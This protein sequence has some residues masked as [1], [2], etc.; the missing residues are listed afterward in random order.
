MNSNPD[1]KPIRFVD[2]N[3]NELFIVPDG[4]YISM[5]RMDGLEYFAQCGY[6]DDYS[7]FYGDVRLDIVDFMD[8]RE[9][10]GTIVKAVEP[11]A[12]IGG[13]RVDSRIA[14]GQKVFV[15]AVNRKVAKSKQYCTWQTHDGKRIESGIRYFPDGVESGIDI[16]RRAAGEHSGIP[17]IPV[18]AE[19]NTRRRGDVR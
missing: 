1:N 2:S 10:N 18:P 5:T 9:Q 3:Y 15:S 11:P 13:Y 17:Y 16:M 4:G 6:I 8:R 14:V 19:K 7:F 12:I